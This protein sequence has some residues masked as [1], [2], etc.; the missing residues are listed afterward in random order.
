MCVS[1][2]VFGPPQSFPGAAGSNKQVH[3]QQYPGCDEQQD[4][5]GDGDDADNRRGREP[6]TNVAL[7]FREP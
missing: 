1:F 4:E 6:V 3:D 7:R 5:D 2:V